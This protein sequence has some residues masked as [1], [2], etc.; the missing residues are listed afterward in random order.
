[1]SNSIFVQ[2]YAFIYEHSFIHLLLMRFNQLSVA[3]W[4]INKYFYT[5]YYTFSI[6]LPWSFSSDWC[7]FDQNC[8][9]C[10]WCLRELYAIAIN[11]SSYWAIRLTGIV[12]RRVSSFF[13]KT[14][15]SISFKFLN[16]FERT[17]EICGLLTPGILQYVFLVLE[18]LDDT[19]GTVQ[20][21]LVQAFL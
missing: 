8:R 20:W 13:V 10:I 18:G 6:I 4:S 17:L 5:L 19:F 1:M 16:C 7:D 9:W 11:W 2:I 14:F 3:M 15:T 21:R 12:D